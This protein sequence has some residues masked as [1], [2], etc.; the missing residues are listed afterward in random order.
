MSSLL[1][2]VLRAIGGI[3]S[4]QDA[5]EQDRESDGV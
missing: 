2:I 3:V 1:Y 5:R 4:D